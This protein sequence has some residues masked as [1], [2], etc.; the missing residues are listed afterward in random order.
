[1]SCVPL[2]WC[3]SKSAIATR[4]RPCAT[5]ACAAPTATLLNRQ[6][7]IASLRVAWWPGGRTAQNARRTWPLL[8]TAS[9]AA[10]TAPAARS[11]ASAEPG[12]S[13]VSSSSHC[14]SPIG[15]VSSTRWTC[16]SS[17]TRSSW[18][19]VARGASTRS[20]AA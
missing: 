3:T 17:C 14:V 10:T 16:A 9:T 6:N 18:S 8:S 4:R 5:I 19:R 2:P 13:A 12:D 11:A 1:M 20:R 7:P 15:T